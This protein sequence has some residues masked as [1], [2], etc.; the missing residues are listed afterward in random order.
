MGVDG[1]VRKL[2]ESAAKTSNSPR[3]LEARNSCR[4]DPRRPELGE[5]DHSALPEQGYRA[6]LLPV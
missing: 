5:A 6:V 1:C 2:V 3:A 4:R